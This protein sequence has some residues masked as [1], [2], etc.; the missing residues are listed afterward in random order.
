[1]HTVRNCFLVIFDWSESSKRR[2]GKNRRGYATENK[3]I[4]IQ[5]QKGL[6]CNSHKSLGNEVLLNTGCFFIYRGL[7]FDL[8]PSFLV[9]FCS[10]IP[11]FLREMIRNQMRYKS[12]LYHCQVSRN[13]P[14]RKR[15][16]FYKKRSIF[17]HFARDRE[18]MIPKRHQIT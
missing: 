18:E 13:M 1:M 14:V 2:E 5:N 15:R 3:N 12:Q 7:W 8:L 10:S 9:R 4:L 6:C 16:I 11:H 17:R